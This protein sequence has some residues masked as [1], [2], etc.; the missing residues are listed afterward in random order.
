MFDKYE[1]H[2][3]PC[4]IRRWVIQLSFEKKS[5]SLQKELGFKTDELS[6]KLT[7]LLNSRRSSSPHSRSSMW[8][9]RR[10]HMQEYVHNESCSKRWGE[11]CL[12]H[13]NWVIMWI[14]N[15]TLDGNVWESI[16]IH[17]SCS[18]MKRLDHRSYETSQRLSFEKE[19]EVKEWPVIASSNMCISRRINSLWV[20]KCGFLA[21]TPKLKDGDSK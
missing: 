11:L 21:M 4:G 2:L 10:H 6:K 12:C 1:L 16:A 18:E 17:D 15:L 5:H 9:K 13:K 3:A 19:G 8:L 7:N 14:E 20:P